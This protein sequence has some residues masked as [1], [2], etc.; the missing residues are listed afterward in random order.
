MY[1]WKKSKGISVI[2]IVLA[3]LLAGLSQ[4]S[5]AAYE[6]ESM[7]RRDPFVPLVGVASKGTLGGLEGIDSV[8]NI[9]FQGV[10]IGADGKKAA[11]INGE[12]FQEGDSIGSVSV[13]SIK[14]N[15]ITVKINDNWHQIKLYE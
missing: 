7:G 2:L 15:E 10:V 9:S 14:D 11:I 12:I 1:L 3:F 6:Y 13:E 4:A 5:F 8:E